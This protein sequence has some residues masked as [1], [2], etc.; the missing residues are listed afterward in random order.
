MKKKLI[1]FLFVAVMALTVFA[2]QSFAEEGTI[3]DCTYVYEDGVLTI[4]GE[5]ALPD[6]YFGPARNATTIIFNEGV[7]SIP[8]DF[9]YNNKNLVSVT[10]ASSVETISKNAFR[11]T[12]NLSELQFADLS[13]SRLSTIG[14]SA[15]YSS[16]IQ[17]VEFNNNLTTISDFAFRDCQKLVTANMGNNISSIG[18]N[19]FSYCVELTNITILGDYTTIPVEAFWSCYKLVNPVLSQTYTTI[20]DHAFTGTYALTGIELPSTLTKIEHTAF[21]WSGLVSIVIPNGVTEIYE[22][23]FYKCTAL[24]SITLPANLQSL[25]TYAL[26]ETGLT[27]VE[28]PGSL[29]VIGDQAFAYC[30]NLKTLKI[31][32]GVESIGLYSF[33]Q[34]GVEEIETPSTLTSISYGAFH[35]CKSLKT[36][37]VGENLETIGYMA[38]AYCSGLESINLP[39]SLS[40]LD[41]YAFWECSS[42]KSI[43]I[44]SQLQT[45]GEGV[46]YKTTSMTVDIVLPGTLINISPRSFYQSG[47]TGVTFS[48]GIYNIQE[49][50]FNRCYNLKTV[51]IPQTCKIIGDSAFYYTGLTDAYI[52]SSVDTITGKN[53]F[54]STGLPEGQRLVIHTEADAEEVIAWVNTYNRGILDTTYDPN[55]AEHECEFGAWTETVAPTVGATG[56]LTKSCECGKSE[57]YTLPALN[58]TDYVY[59]ETPATCAAVGTGTYTIT[60]DGQTFTY[61]VELPKV[62]HEYGDWVNTTPAT[63]LDA[64]VDSKACACGDTIT[65]PVAY[66]GQAVALDVVVNGTTATATLKIVGAPDLTSIG[67]S[68]A[69]ANKLTLTAAESLLEGYTVDPNVANPVK[70]VWINGEANEDI[71]GDVLVLTFEIAEDAEI[72][73]EDFTITYDADDVC[74]LDEGDALVNVELET[75][76][77]VSAN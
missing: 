65:R 63:P 18:R 26:A 27:F 31:N 73:A 9:C 51:V 71:N 23:T 10:L 64:G 53:A 55:A 5:G 54:Y 38:F 74:V 61:N 13:T 66:E 1:S 43:T 41:H 69:Y 7:T 16:G 28:I 62:D 57:T 19:A 17:S 76:V 32:E 42:L 39:D 3:G 21:N 11:D 25:G 40:T 29:K 46:F 12:S 22:T 8:A 72:S 37:T 14:V 70:F 44:P 4:S 33:I 20:K 49:N 68:I 30:K 45:L 47:I 58:N 35:T 36:V 34:A 75:F 24:T 15:F 60:V 6:G 67:F 2:V 50:S 77:K 48:E 56:T 59:T 52:P